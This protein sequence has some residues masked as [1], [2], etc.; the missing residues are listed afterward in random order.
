[1][2]TNICD[3]CK[4]KAFLLYASALQNDNVVLSQEECRTLFKLLEHEYIPYENAEAHAVVARIVRLALAKKR[5]EEKNEEHP[6][7]SGA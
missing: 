3:V 7:R 5:K 6:D 4:D 1:M 2:T